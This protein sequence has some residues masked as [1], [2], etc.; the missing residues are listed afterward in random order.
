MDGVVFSLYCHELFTDL[1]LLRSLP[2]SGF[3][4][5]S[6]QDLPAVRPLVLPFCIS[7][8]GALEDNVS[9][10]ELLLI[11]Q[12]LVCVFLGGFVCLKKAQPAEIFWVRKLLVCSRL[13]DAS[14]RLGS[15][16]GSWLDNWC[17]PESPMS[18][19]AWIFGH[20]TVGSH[21]VEAPTL[22]G[23]GSGFSL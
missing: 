17:F 19:S 13:Y 9:W 10:W 8:S 12:F 3:P 22:H 21:D 6:L 2:F 15:G 11:G 23:S 4:L 18:L 20:D 5:L 1:F 16:L 14:L 7:W